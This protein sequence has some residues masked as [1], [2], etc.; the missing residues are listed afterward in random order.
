MRDETINE[1]A[2]VRY[3]L[4]Q[5]SEA[6]QEQ[7]EAGYL[8]D[9]EFFERLLAAEDD[10][11]DAYARGGL[12]EAAR[13]RFENYFLRSAERRERV[14]FAREWLTFVSR[15]AAAKTEAA[16]GRRVSWRESLRMK[17]F[18]VWIPLAAALVLAL[19]GVWLFV[20]TAQ[21]RR[22]LE[23]LR[24][25][26]AAAESREQELRQQVADERA[27][28]QQ[29]LDELERERARRDLE[30]RNQVET[31]P[32]RSGIVAFVLNL[33]LVR[34]A[35]EGRRLVIPP[36]ARQVRLRVHFKVGDYRR[37]RAALE[38]VEGREVWSRAGLSAQRRGRDKTVV[39][40]VPAS[41]LR[42]EDYI[43]TLSGVTATGDPVG[44][45]EYAFRVIR[46]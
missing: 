8:G 12:P 17:N 4:G 46:K 6:E 36:D 41:V 15:P 32:S 29:L 27:R 21:W 7:V 43:L 20:Q 19:G 16:P 34:S 2:L 40:N 31:P 23:Q 39:L 18:A 14:E 30:N 5:M 10:L 3:L 35:A 1:E 25:E 13:E 45:G 42:D 28:S 44:V 11:I 37:Y 26:K 22:Q 9:R 24:A 38:T 33:G